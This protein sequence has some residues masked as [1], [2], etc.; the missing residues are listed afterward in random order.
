[1][2]VVHPG[3]TKGAGKKRNAQKD[4]E[5]AVFPRDFFAQGSRGVLYRESV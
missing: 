1:M 4:T 2:D 5:V 3:A